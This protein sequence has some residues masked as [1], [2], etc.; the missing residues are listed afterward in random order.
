MEAHFC[1]WKT[2]TIGRHSALNLLQMVQSSTDEPYDNVP[3]YYLQTSSCSRAFRI[4]C[5]YMHRTGSTNNKSK[6]NCITL[7]LLTQAE[8][9][10]NA[11][12]YHQSFIR[13]C[14]YQ[15]SIPH[16]EKESQNVSE[17]FHHRI[18]RPKTKM[19]AYPYVLRDEKSIWIQQFLQSDF[20]HN[21]Y[22]KEELNKFNSTKQCTPFS[23]GI[24]A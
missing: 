2:L 9:N 19:I 21:N 8:D 15:C 11:T 23:M 22:K 5:L 7:Y 14:R 13:L 10:R 20:S 12:F 24:F 3:K 6:T 4:Y 1:C 16:K 17:N 18:K